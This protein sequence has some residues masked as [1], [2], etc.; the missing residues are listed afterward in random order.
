MKLTEGCEG[1]SDTIFV[2]EVVRKLDCQV[3]G[4]DMLGRFFQLLVL[5]SIVAVSG[6]NTPGRH[7]EVGLPVT[8]YATGPG[9]SGFEYPDNWQIVGV[10]RE[11]N[12]SELIHFVFSEVADW[13]VHESQKG[14][15]ASTKCF[16]SVAPNQAHQSPVHV[17]RALV[18]F[19]EEIVEAMEGKNL[20]EYVENNYAE[21][22]RST[23]LRLEAGFEVPG[24]RTVEFWNRSVAPISMQKHYDYSI[25]IQRKIIERDSYT[26]L[27]TGQP[28]YRHLY[29]S[30]ADVTLNTIVP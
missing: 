15:W 6:C 7:I 25:F 23:G 5:V 19:M 30:L 3:C 10:K 20:S 12:G 4:G 17:R 8:Y 2:C 18:S 22:E 26:F 16:L 1:D 11:N 13:K 9:V 14:L 24:V 28:R 27:C 29:A 21:Y